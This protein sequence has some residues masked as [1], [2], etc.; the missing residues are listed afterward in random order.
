MLIPLFCS[1][2][3][4]FFEG[5]AVNQII[6]VGLFKS[7]ENI[8]RK[9]ILLK[10]GLLWPPNFLLSESIKNILRRTA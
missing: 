5:G 7:S 6:T 3:M 9:K 2:G 1:E 4:R 10:S 8:Q